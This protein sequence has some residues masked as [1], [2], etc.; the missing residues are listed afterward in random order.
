MIPAYTLKRPHVGKGYPG[1]A[2]DPGAGFFTQRGCADGQGTRIT[3]GLLR[4][5]VHRVRLTPDDGLPAITGN[6]YFRFPADHAVND[7]LC[8]KITGIIVDRRVLFPVR[9]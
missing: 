7:K 5:K 8:G 1:I 2:E 3:T 6:I 9:V 4:R